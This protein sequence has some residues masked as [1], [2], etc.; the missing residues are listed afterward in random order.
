[1]N[2]MQV[3]DT[4]TQKKRLAIC[5]ACPHRIETQIPLTKKRI[6]HCAQCGCLLASKTKFARAT[7]PLHKW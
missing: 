2:P 7:C 4:E 1:M 5:A 3:V 6:A